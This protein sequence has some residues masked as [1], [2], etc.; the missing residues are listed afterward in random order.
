MNSLSNPLM[1]REGLPKFD[2]VTPDDFIPAVKAVFAKTEE[3][4]KEVEEKSEPTWD[5]LL[6]PFEETDLD[7]E[8][9]WSVMS[10]LISVKNSEALRKA[11]EQL[12]PEC[13]RVSLKMSQSKPRYNR[14]VALRDSAG[15]KKLNDAKKRI[16][17]SQ[18]KSAEKSGIALDGEKKERF[19]AI[20]KRMSE[21]SNKFSNNILDS[22]KAFGL[23]VTDKADTEGWPD[24][25]RHLSAVSYAK[26]NNTRPNPQN[27]PWLI[28]LDSPSYLPF[29]Q[30]CRNRELRS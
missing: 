19:N 30:H 17:Q 4:L 15:F 8:Y 7:W 21:I 22:T 20:V 16:I 3:V 9:T 12:M 5:S 11:Y 24:T 6:R 27:G 13:V 2:Q 23:V 18:I 1:Q 25:L 26:K 14:L 10:H 29:M 28:T